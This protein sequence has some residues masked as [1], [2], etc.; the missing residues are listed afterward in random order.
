[1]ADTNRSEQLEGRADHDQIRPKPTFV[2]VALLTEQAPCERLLDVVRSEEL[3][4][5]EI[6][7]QLI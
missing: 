4:H 7:H 5:D 2:E 1:M 6:D 3:R